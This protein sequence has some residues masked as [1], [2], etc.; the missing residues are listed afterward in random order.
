MQGLPDTNVKSYYY[1]HWHQWWCLF[2][3]HFLFNAHSSKNKIFS[4]I[5]LHYNLW[6]ACLTWY[7]TCP[8]MKTSCYCVTLWRCW[9]LHVRPSIIFKL[10]AIALGFSHMF[11]MKPT[12]YVWVMGAANGNWHSAVAV[13]GQTG[14][15]SDIAA[16]P[17]RWQWPSGRRRCAR[18]KLRPDWLLQLSLVSYTVLC[19]C[20]TVGE[21][22]AHIVVWLDSIY[23]VILCMFILLY[24]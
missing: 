5:D 19:M 21:I 13:C 17:G 16:G 10:I 11:I 23:Y 8:P 9:G 15:Q 22:A 12:S 1:W 18:S 7:Y 4:G 6:M 20:S 24:I 3:S 2:Y 14:I